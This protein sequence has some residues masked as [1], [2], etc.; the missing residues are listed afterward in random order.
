MSQTYCSIRKKLS[1]GEIHTQN[2]HGFHRGV[3]PGFWLQS[4]PNS[5]FLMLLYG[6]DIKLI[7]LKANILIKGLI[8]ILDA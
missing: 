3:N 7:F 8:L 2:L 1:S 5:V 6:S 4:H